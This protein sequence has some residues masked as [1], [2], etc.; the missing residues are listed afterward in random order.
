MQ[1]TDHSGYMNNQALIQ[2]QML[3]ALSMLNPS[4]CKE[5]VD[6]AADTLLDNF[7]L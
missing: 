5:A 4:W 2:H 7:A 3:T 6:I 1:G